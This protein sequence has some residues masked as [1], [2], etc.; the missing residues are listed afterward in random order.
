MTLSYMD[1]RATICVRAEELS[2]LSAVELPHWH[3]SVKRNRR[4]PEPMLQSEDTP[5]RGEGGSFALGNKEPCLYHR[6]RVSLEL[7][8]FLEEIGEVIRRFELFTYAVLRYI[9]AP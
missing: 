8:S 1:M 6:R 3:T 7:L 4:H 2:L 9:L 5:G